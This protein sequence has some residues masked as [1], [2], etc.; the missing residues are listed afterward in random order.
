M[1]SAFLAGMTVSF[2]AE[3][4]DKSQLVVLT[5]GRTSSVARTVL[6]LAGVIVVLQGTA[7]AVG[8]LVGDVLPESWVGAAAGVLFLLF[9]YL[10]WRE[11]RQTEVGHTQPAPKAGL[12]RLL[13]MFFVAELGDKTNLATAN[14]AARLDPVATWLGASAGMLAATLVALAVGVWMRRTIGGRRLGQM[15]ALAFAVAGVITLVSAVL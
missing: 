7:A 8:G 12:A 5:H 13:G 15:G 2:L 4:G 6:G 3:L 9:A 10:T 11:T 14:L 1:G